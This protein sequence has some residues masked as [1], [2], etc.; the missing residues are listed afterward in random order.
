MTEPVNPLFTITNKQYN[1]F[2]K[3][4][5]SGVFSNSNGIYSNSEANVI[6]IFNMQETDLAKLQFIINAPPEFSTEFSFI[7]EDVTVTLADVRPNATFRVNGLKNTMNEFIQY[8]QVNSIIKLPN[9]FPVYVFTPFYNDVAP[10]G[11]YYLIPQ[12]TDTLSQLDP[13]VVRTLGHVKYYNLVFRLTDK[14]YI[15]ELK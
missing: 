13:G 11:N 4:S 14:M 10:D 1:Y 12:V 2:L 6:R 7:L 3:Q 9:S 15:P 8:N 5:L